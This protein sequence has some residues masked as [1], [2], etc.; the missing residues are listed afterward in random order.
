M[1][2]GI[3]IYFGMTGLSIIIGG[4]TTGIGMIGDGI[5]GTTHTTIIGITAGIIGDGIIELITTGK[6][7]IQT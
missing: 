5:V 1:S 6:E 4:L 3:D 2:T 7:I